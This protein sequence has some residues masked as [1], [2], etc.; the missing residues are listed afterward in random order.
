VGRSLLRR[1]DLIWAA[2]FADGHHTQPCRRSR[3]GHV[4]ADVSPLILILVG[5]MLEPT[6][7]VLLRFG[8]GRILAQIMEAIGITLAC[9]AVLVVPA[10]LLSRRQRH[11]LRR[12]RRR[13]MQDGG[14]WFL[15]GND[16]SAEQPHHHDHGHQHDSGSGGQH[17]GG[18]EGHHGGGFDGGG[19]GGHGGH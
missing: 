8:N 3:F 5:K 11:G 2:V 12:H 7:V 13:S 9:V 17:G 6:H 4:A 19:G 15:G 16:S 18:F 1:R 10:L 14:V